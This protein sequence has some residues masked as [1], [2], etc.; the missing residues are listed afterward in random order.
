[1]IYFPSVVVQAVP[2]GSTW[3][4]KD[5]PYPYPMFIVY[6]IWDYI[7]KPEQWKNLEKSPC[8]GHSAADKKR[9]PTPY[10]GGGPPLANLCKDER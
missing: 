3:Q 6:Y 8:C 9:W 4:V 5:F 10:V 1:M 7:S 2:V